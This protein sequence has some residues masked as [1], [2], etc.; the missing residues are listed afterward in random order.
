MPPAALLFPHPQPPPPFRAASLTSTP[1]SIQADNPTA[2]AFRGATRQAQSTLDSQATQG[3][4]ASQTAAAAAQATQTADAL[5]ALTATSDARAT[6]QAIYT[7]EHTW[8]QR[9]A[10]TFADNQLGWPIGLTQDQYLAVTST[11]AGGRYQWLTQIA[12]SGAYTNLAP[13]KGPSPADFYAAVT[14]QFAPGGGNDQGDAAYGL[15]FRLVGEDFGFFGVLNS[16]S[17]L[18]L[19]THGSNVDQQILDSSS[20]IDTRP[21]ATNRLGVVGVGADFVFLINDQVVSDL[22]ANLAPGQIGLGVEGLSAV[23]QAQVDFSDFEVR[24]P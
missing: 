4:L 1:P 14:V 11:V 5:T 7:A 18:A 6:V 24:A 8:P 23:K 19:E 21:G 22:A 9:V 2:A 17:Y 12:M 13:A 20:A 15:A 10:E 3:P 16:G